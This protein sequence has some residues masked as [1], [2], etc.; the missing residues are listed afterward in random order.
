MNINY[1]YC[2]L[3]ITKSDTA[4]NEKF[5]IPQNA[6]VIYS[7]LMRELDTVPKREVETLLQWENWILSPCFSRIGYFPVGCENSDTLLLE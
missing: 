3:P 2:T 6:K 4:S 5:N 1:I 7:S